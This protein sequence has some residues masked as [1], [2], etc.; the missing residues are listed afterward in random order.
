MKIFFLKITFFIILCLN[1]NG[2]KLEEIYP[3]LLETASCKGQSFYE[4]KFQDLNNISQELKVNWKKNGVIIPNKTQFG[5]LIK[6][7]G[8]YSCEVWHKKKFIETNTLIFAENTY[9]G[10][11]ELT[12]SS[13]GNY[14]YFPCGSILTKIIAPFDTN[15]FETTYDWYVNNQLQEN[16]SSNFI[17]PNNIKSNKFMV[18][19]IV[20]NGECIFQSPQTEIFTDSKSIDFSNT[21]TSYELCKGDSISL[22]RL[23]K[24]FYKGCC[25]FFFANFDWYK[26]GKLIESNNWKSG[27][28]GGDALMIKEAGTYHVVQTFPETYYLNN[29]EK[30]NCIIRS[31]NII[32]TKK[33]TITLEKSRIF[34][35]RNYFKD[36]PELTYTIRNDGLKS[37][38]WFRN[39]TILL[40]YNNSLGEYYTGQF[41]QYSRKL[42][43]KGDYS[44]QILYENGCLVN[45]PKEYYSGKTIYNLKVDKNCNSAILSINYSD[46]RTNSPILN[47][48]FNDKKIP[49]YYKDKIEIS[50]SGRYKVQDP[51]FDGGKYQL[52]SQE[53]N[54]EFEDDFSLKLIGD[55]A[56][57]V[58]QKA[59]IN[60]VT[61]PI[62]KIL[63]WYENDLTIPISDATI[64][65][66]KK[67]NYSALVTNK[68]CNNYN[69][70]N[71][72]KISE[73]PLPTASISGIKSIDYKESVDLKIEL[74]S[75]P[76]WQIILNNGEEITIN[77]SPYLLAVNPVTDTKYSIESVKNVCGLGKAEGEAL[78]KVIILADENIINQNLNLK[79]YPIPVINQFEIE[80]NNTKENNAELYLYDYTGKIIIKSK[81]LKNGNNIYKTLN[82]SNLNIGTYIL[83]VKL[84]DTILERKIIKK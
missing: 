3:Y 44:A 62:S 84:G 81:A 42:K 9:V 6:E 14:N 35:R 15:I 32:V 20:R 45:L 78:V 8:S 80:I 56:I 11:A 54:V 57:C 4:L 68:N 5:L 60:L 31:E 83:K 50:K 10:K 39:D 24:T 66:N 79:T 58:G 27:E 13:K 30:N 65:V 26:D 12:Y 82:I 2:Q 77:K 37:F 22:S 75:S 53:V 46:H 76:P 1:L 28:F 61:S 74:T 40:D 38:N 29:F 69:L 18:K 52:E 41:T 63:N 23:N 59:T 34:F 73:T 72:L 25:P 21:T 17:Y 71:T 51:Y 33:D 55:T 16:H 70:S 7:A 48:Y 19:G 64:I 43:E 47:W 49:V 36:E 67:G